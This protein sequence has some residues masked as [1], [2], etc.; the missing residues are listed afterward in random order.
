MN[1]NRATIASGGRA[2]S[3]EGRHSPD[4]VILSLACLAQFMVILDISIVNVALPSIQ[5]DLHFTQTGLQ[6]VVNAY[7]L[8]FAGFLLLGGRAADLYGRRRIFILGLGLFSLASLVGGLSQSSSMLT[9]ARGAQGLGGAVLSPAT[10]TIL[11]TTFPEGKARSRALGIWSAVAG[12]GGAA[13]ALFGGLLTTYVSWRW[14]LFV[15]VPIG[16]AAMVT[17][18]VFLNEGR[19]RSLQRSLDVPGA[20]TVTAGLA[21]LVYAIVNTTSHPWTSAQTLST[22][23]VALVLLVA[24]VVIEGR[25]A[26]APLMPLRLFRSRS[27]SGANL[28]MLLVGVAMFA[29][30]FLVS[31]YLQLVLH[32]SALRAGLAFL[33][34][35]VAIVAGTQV[36]S[37]LVDRLGPRPLVLVGLGLAAGGF[38]WMGQISPASS[39]AGSVLGPGMLLTLGMGL[40]FTPLATAATAG[41]SRR[42]AGL[43]SGLL[44]TSRQIGGSIG[45]AVLVTLAT[46]RT[47]AILAGA[48]RHGGRPAGSAVAGALTAGYARGFKV[49]AAVAAA[50]ALAAFIVP[51]VR[52]SSRGTG[53][54]QPSVDVVDPVVSALVLA[55]ASRLVETADGTRPGLLEAAASL[56]P[57]ARGSVHD[58]ASRAAREVLR[59]LARQ[60]LERARQTGGTAPEHSTGRPRPG[61]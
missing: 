11:I 42:E 24:F 12:A 3:V 16:M 22:L 25:F 1:T 53:P 28:V 15:N 52:R 5:R 9:A 4:W 41:V 48:A 59:P 18:L 55:V 13:G 19:R 29:M 32:Y 7:T 56:V 37:R 45:L 39:Y 6:W 38:L 2:L 23:G 8:A 43:A 31:L 26:P 17:A 46:D 50:A 51:S 35:S 33:P 61:E 27:L 10:L 54:V 34:L 44:N 58:R 20:V 30:F 40:S 14:I 47:Q 36:A 49:A 60:V 57:E 21:L